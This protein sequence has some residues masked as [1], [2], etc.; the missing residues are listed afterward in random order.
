MRINQDFHAVIEIAAARHGLVLTCDLRTLGFGPSSIRWMVQS[1]MLERIVRGLYRLAGSR[2]RVQ[3]MAAAA[4]RHRGGRIS[5]T[6]ALELG[7]M[8]VGGPKRP[9]LTLP[10]GATHESALAEIHRSWVEP[11]DRC[12]I[13]GIPSVSL[14]RA[15]VDAGEVLSQ[16]QLDDVADEL[17]GARGVGVSQILGAIERIECAPGRK[18]VGKVRRAIA[19][20]TDAVRPESPAEAALVRR[21]CDAGITRPVTQHEIRTDDGSF[22]ARVDLAWPDRRVAREYESRRHHTPRTTGHDEERRRAIEAAG[23]LVRP[24]YPSDVQG[25]NSRWLDRLAGDLRRDGYR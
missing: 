1:A 18:G 20:W 10:P 13:A 9:F 19:S 14:P 11:I 16:S 6:S 22:V 7:G 12:L 15:F 5:H 21:I 2:T 17:L 24:I 23:W 3:D 25:S 8:Q 4:I